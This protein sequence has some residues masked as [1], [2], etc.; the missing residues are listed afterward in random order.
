MMSLVFGENDISRNRGDVGDVVDVKSQLKVMNSLPDYTTHDER[1]QRIQQ[2]VFM[3]IDLLVQAKVVHFF[4][5]VLVQILEVGLR[6]AIRIS[7]NSSMID[8]VHCLVP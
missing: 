5:I 6:K 4:N 2:L 8:L 1:H 3:E 7:S